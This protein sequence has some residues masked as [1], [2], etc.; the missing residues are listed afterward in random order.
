[1]KRFPSDE[2]RYVYTKRFRRRH[3]TAHAAHVA[4]TSAVRAGRLVRPK[5]CPECG[6][7]GKVQAHHD[8]YSQP[9]TVRWMCRTCH[10]KWHARL[11]SAWTVQQV[12]YRLNCAD[13]L[14]RR[15]IAAGKLPATKVGRDWRIEPDDLDA[16]LARGRTAP[17]PQPSCDLPPVANP[18]FS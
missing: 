9:L 5:A 16:F 6:A 8:D 18:R 13:S 1:M 15:L 2:R 14:V 7:S 3:P 17:M 12:S 10:R 4:V 11:A